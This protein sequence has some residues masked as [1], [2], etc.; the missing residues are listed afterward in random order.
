[1]KNPEWVDRYVSEVLKLEGRTKRPLIKFRN[2]RGTGYTHYKWKW[3]NGKRKLIFTYI[4]INSNGDEKWDKMIVLHELAHAMGR[5]RS[6]HNLRFWERAWRYYE[7]F[8][9]E[10]DWEAVKKSEFSYMGKAKIVYDRL[11]PEVEL[12]LGQLSL[13]I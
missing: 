12:P 2:K 13:A 11:Y 4:S 1:M 3:K 6:H 10:L 7:A 5:P 9:N 8:R